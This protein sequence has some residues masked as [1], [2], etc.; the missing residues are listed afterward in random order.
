VD[1]NEVET[2]KKEVDEAQGR[3]REVDSKFNKGSKESL[4]TEV[5]SVG[6]EDEL[7]VEDKLGVKE[8]AK[9]IHVAGLNVTVEGRK[10]IRTR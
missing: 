3:L 1:N 8:K 4:G 2:F 7:C 6:V 10:I 9:G 5:K